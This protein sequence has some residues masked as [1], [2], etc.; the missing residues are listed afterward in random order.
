MF[1]TTNQIK[2]IGVSCRR[3]MEWNPQYFIHH[4]LHG[5]EAPKDPQVKP[6]CRH[7]QY[8]CCLFVEWYEKRFLEQD[9]KKGAKKGLRKIQRFEDPSTIQNLKT[10]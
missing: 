5:M 2:L 6:F 7:F 8:G 3:K 10:N 9:P 1:E 4:L